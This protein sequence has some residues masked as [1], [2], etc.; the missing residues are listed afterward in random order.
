MTQISLPQ[1]PCGETEIG[2]KAEIYCYTGCMFI[3]Q[4]GAQGI[5]LNLAWR[6]K[7]T[8]TYEVVFN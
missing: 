8:F 1:E 4:L 7:E 5:S 2:E 3:F 6:V